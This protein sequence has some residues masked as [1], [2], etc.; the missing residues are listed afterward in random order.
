MFC[1]NCGTKNPENGQYCTSCGKGIGQHEAAVAQPAAAAA[2][3]KIL[4]LPLGGFIGA[5][6]G[7]LA[8]I[9]AAVLVVVSLI[10]KPLPTESNADSFLLRASDVSTFQSGKSVDSVSTDTSDW[11][12]GSCD[13]A[14]NLTSHLTAGTSW[15]INDFDASS[16]TT[17]SFWITSQIIKFDTEAE[18]Q[19]VLNDLTTAATDSSCDTP[20]IGDYYSG[21]QTVKDKYGVNLDGVE[22]TDKY[23]GYQE[24]PPTT[25]H[26]IA[27]RRGSILLVLRTSH[28]DDYAAVSLNDEKNIITKALNR[29]AGN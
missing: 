23:D 26:F 25:S 7:A 21:G 28:A 1:S 6:A 29:F 11:I 13:S 2:P 4:G 10:P 18:A 12:Y 17:N 5:A 19:A 27:S 14:T 22:L 9:V 24:T 20:D 8:V 3:K 15:A 16:D